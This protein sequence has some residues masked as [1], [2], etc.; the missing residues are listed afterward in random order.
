MRGW[1]EASKSYEPF[2]QSRTIFSMPKVKYRHVYLCI[3][4]YTYIHMSIRVHSW[5][6]THICIYAKAYTYVHTYILTYIQARY[7]HKWMHN[8][9]VYICMYIFIGTDST[10]WRHFSRTK[11]GNY[12]FDTSKEE[13][14]NVCWFVL[15]K[16]GMFTWI[17]LWT[18]IH[19]YGC[20][21]L[22]SYV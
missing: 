7:L 19:T 18:Y 5:I 1:C 15:G 4:E 22:V 11:F 9:I 6:H 13:S 20:A 14:W 16:Q 10:L 12:F 2:K 3:H 8:G 21:Y 17:Y